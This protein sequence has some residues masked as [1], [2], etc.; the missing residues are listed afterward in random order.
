MFE[1]PGVCARVYF[2]TP[3]ARGETYT[4]R[5]S[6]HYNRAVDRASIRVHK[7]GKG[8]TSLM[9]VI[10]AGDCGCT[11]EVKL[12]KLP[13]KSALKG[14]YYPSS[15]AEALKIEVRGKEYVAVICHQEVNS[16][17]DLVEVD[18]C[19]GFGNVIVFDKSRDVLVGTVMNY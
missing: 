12:T 1:A 17:T 5:I 16:P 13:V 4:S 3:G 8:F 14:I 11:P 15:M 18:G 7:E 6:R 10:C 19:L 2:M 9:T